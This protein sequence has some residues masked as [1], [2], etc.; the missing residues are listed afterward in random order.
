MKPAEIGL[1]GATKQSVAETIREWRD[2][3][4]A[5]RAEREAA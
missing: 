1:F 3:R 5:I 2:E 4:E